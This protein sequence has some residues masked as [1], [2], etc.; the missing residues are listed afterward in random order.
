M[1]GDKS[2]LVTER[3][4]RDIKAGHLSRLLLTDRETASAVMVDTAIET[5]GGNGALC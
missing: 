4:R 5:N 2:G 1:C 3:V